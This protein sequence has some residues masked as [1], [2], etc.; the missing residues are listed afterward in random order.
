VI[1]CTPIKSSI[2]SAISI[3]HLLEMDRQTQGHSIYHDS[4][5]SHR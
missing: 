3:E 5:V 1:A 2:L 4:I